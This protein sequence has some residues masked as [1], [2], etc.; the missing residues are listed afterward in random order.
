MLGKVTRKSQKEIKIKKSSSIGPVERVY[1]D[2]V[3]SISVPSAGGGKYFITLL[4]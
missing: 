1:T 4:Y 3:G 2:V